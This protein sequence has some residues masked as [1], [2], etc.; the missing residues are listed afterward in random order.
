[1]AKGGP[2]TKPFG[3]GQPVP[4]GG[5]FAPGTSGNPGGKVSLK[6]THEWACAHDPDFA[7]VAGVSIEEARGRLYAL[8]MK[9]AVQGPKGPKDTNWTFAAG[10]MMTRHFGKPKESVDISGDVSPEAQ[11][12]LAALRMTPHERREA[13]AA[14]NE[15]AAAMDAATADDEGD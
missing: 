11:A 5:R 9:I 3:S 2:P 4:R 15:D 12:L 6:L 7:A 14:D 8:M 1:M 13:L 10:E